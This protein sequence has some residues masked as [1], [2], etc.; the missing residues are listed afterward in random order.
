LGT[1][2]YVLPARSMIVTVFSIHYFCIF[3][4]HAVAMAFMSLYWKGLGYPP[5]WMNIA[6]AGLSVGGL[7]GAPATMR[8]ANTVISP[9]RLLPLLPIGMAVGFLL[10]PVDAPPAIGPIAL[11]FGCCFLH[12]GSLSLMDYLSCSEGARQGF[13]YEQVRVWGSIG[14]MIGAQIAGS[15]LDISSYAFIPL[16]GALFAAATGVSG[17]FLSRYVPSTP[18][19]LIHSSSRAATAMPWRAF[20]PLLAAWLLISASHATLYLLLSIHLENLG[21]SGTWISVA[22]NVGIGAEVAVFF[23]YSRIESL[24]SHRKLFFLAALVTAI[25]WA[26]LGSTVSTPFI[27]ASQLLHAVSFGCLHITSMRLTQKIVPVERQPTGQALLSACGLGMGV[28]FGT[29][30]VNAGLYWLAGSSDPIFQLFWL[31]AALAL[32]A[33]LITSFFPDLRE[34]EP[35]VSSVQVQH[36]R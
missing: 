15:L 4:I 11:W 33:A 28:L 16:I 1:E 21:W 12:T 31:S 7:L 22:W 14:C 8:L 19:Q 3:C 10:L 25:R 24:L 13:R 36:R 29:A 34:S 23:L 9:Q 20:S 6:T 2:L 18:L 32:L 30:L 35:L 5:D 27:L 26:L 17:L